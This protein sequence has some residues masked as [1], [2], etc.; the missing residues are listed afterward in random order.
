MEMKR[1]TEHRYII[2]LNYSAQVGLVDSFSLT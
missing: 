1:N 2:F